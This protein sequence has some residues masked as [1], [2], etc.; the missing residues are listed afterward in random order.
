MYVCVWF[1]NLLAG[2]IRILLHAC[3]T[4]PVST[5]K[6]VHHQSLAGQVSENYFSQRAQATVHSYKGI[7]L[8]T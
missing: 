6:F 2:H 4:N 5:C 3:W 7:G 8:N 1:V